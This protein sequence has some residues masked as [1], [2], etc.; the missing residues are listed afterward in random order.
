VLSERA[1][2][3]QALLFA[4][5]LAEQGGSGLADVLLGR[6]EP[7]GRLARTLPR[8]TGETP[9]HSGHRSVPLRTAGRRWWSLAISV[10]PRA[11]DRPTFLS[12]R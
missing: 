5:P 6:T 8:A 10:S 2:Q 3:V 1:G 9:L 12:M 11:L 7:T 4:G